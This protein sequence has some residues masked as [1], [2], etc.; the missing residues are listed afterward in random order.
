MYSKYCILNVLYDLNPNITK[1]RTHKIM[2]FLY[3]EY[4]KRNKKDLFIPNFQAWRYGPVEVDIYYFKCNQSNE[5]MTKSDIN[6]IHEIYKYYEVY[7]DFQLV[8]ISHESIPWIMKY[9]IKD[10]YHNKPISSKFI[11]DCIT[12]NYKV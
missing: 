5:T 8:N 10:I 7:S 2:Y 11:K 4:Y 3:V 1:I 12:S 6:F 9:N